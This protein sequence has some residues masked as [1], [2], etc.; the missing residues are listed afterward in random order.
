MN[1]ILRWFLS[2]ISNVFIGCFAL[3]ANLS[4][5]GFNNAVVKALLSLFKAIGLP[6]FGI[7]ILVLLIKMMMAI[8]DG[9]EVNFGDL[10]QRCLFG[11]IIYMYGVN[12]V[13]YLYLYLLDF[14]QD[15][16]A[17]IAG[18]ND[19]DVDLFDFTFAGQEL[20]SLMIFIMMVI[21]VFYM[22]KTFLNLVERFWLLVVTLLMLYL[23]LPGYVAGNDESLILWFKQSVAIGL[24]QV[25]QTIIVVFGIALFANGGGIDDFALSI[26]AII[27]SSKVDQIM[28]KWGMSAGGKVGNFMRN[29]M[30]TA[31]YATQIFAR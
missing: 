4:N 21:S 22:M 19:F 17:V 5:S 2:Q 10:I 26:G 20:S 25:M 6:L 29:G 15:I 27:A 31:F 8:W 16:L 28:D 11:T 23:Y 7:A 1:L 18:V 9:K 12:F 3:V 24:T 30:S 13:K 14:A